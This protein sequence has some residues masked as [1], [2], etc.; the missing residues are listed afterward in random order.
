MT[1]EDFDKQLRKA[2][3]ELQSQILESREKQKN[4][5]VTKAAMKQ[6]IRVAE[7]VKS[8]LEQLPKDEDRAVYRIVGRAFLQETTASGSLFRFKRNNVVLEKWFRPQ[9]VLRQSAI[10]LVCP[11]DLTGTL[12]TDLGYLFLE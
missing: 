3:Q 5:D 12:R 7:I 11:Q 8:Q 9:L 1:E 4:A 10:N 2:F 6:N